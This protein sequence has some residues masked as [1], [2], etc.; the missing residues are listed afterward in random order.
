MEIVKSTVVAHAPASG[1][2]VY[3]VVVWLLTVGAHVPF[4]PLMEVV[5]KAGKAEL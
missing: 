2:K 4:I 3:V 5:G 1:V